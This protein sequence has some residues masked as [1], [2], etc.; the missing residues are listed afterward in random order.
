MA[1]VMSPLARDLEARRDRSEISGNDSRKCFV[2]KFR[3][4]LE[5]PA[6]KLRVLSFWKRNDI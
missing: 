1:R 4:D 5:C 6:K 2:S 3:K